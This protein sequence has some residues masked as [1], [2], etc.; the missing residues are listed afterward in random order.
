MMNGT[1]GMFYQSARS[2]YCRSFA[3]RYVLRRQRMAKKLGTQLAR[4]A[5]MSKPMWALLLPLA[6]LLVHSAHTPQIS[7][8]SA[9]TA[10]GDDAKQAA[11]EGKTPQ[12]IS[13]PTTEP[14]DPSAIQKILA[15]LKDPTTLDSLTPANE[16]KPV[17]LLPTQ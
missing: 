10:N 8:A 17:S 2:A 4:R 6:M 11:A 14:I 7:Q 16:T 15:E 1:I 9:S 12:E 5:M 13:L 3:C